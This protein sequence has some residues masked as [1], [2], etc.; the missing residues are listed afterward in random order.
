MK[1]ELQAKLYEVAVHGNFEYKV[2]KSNKWLCVVECIN[3]NCKWR[4]RGSKLPNSGYFI[5]RKYNGTHTCS[6][7]GRNMNHRQATYRVIGQKFKSQY[8]GVSEGPTPRGLVNLVRENLKA[9]VSYWKGWKVRQYA[10]S[11]IRGSPEESFPLLQ[12]YCHM[13]KLKNPEIVTCIEIDGNKKFKF[14]LWLSM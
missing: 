6:L 2:V 10:H 9:G 3:K 1:D 14:F 13:L 8:V 12:S 5:I 11:L 4:V 7:V